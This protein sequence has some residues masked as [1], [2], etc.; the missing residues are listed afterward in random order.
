[1]LNY[2]DFDAIFFD[3]DGTIFDSETV[4]REAWK[5]TAKQFG[6]VFTDE[7]YLQFIGKTTPNCMKLAAQMFNHQVDMQDF[8]AGYYAN[9]KILLSKSVPLKPGFLAYLDLVKELNKPLGL[10]TSSAMSGVQANFAHYDF[11]DVFKVVVTRDDVRQFKPNPEP[12]ILACELLKVEPQRV[13][14][15][16]D[17]NTGVTAALDAG[18]YSVGIPDLVPFNEEV[19]SRIHIEVAS[20]NSLL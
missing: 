6:Q 7:T 12:Y 19:A 15:F 14:V 20:F 13:L 3:M 4:H 11:Y 1:M 8:S 10:V 5:I 9:L 17:S 18:C 16:E 2:N